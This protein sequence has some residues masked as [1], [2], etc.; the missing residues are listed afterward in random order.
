MF[1]L[2]L[3]RFP[4]PKHKY[5]NHASQQRQKLS[6]QIMGYALLSTI[7]RKQEDCDTTKRGRESK[8]MI[9]YLICFIILAQILVVYETLILHSYFVNTERDRERERERERDRERQRQ[10]EREREREIEAREKEKGYAKEWG[11]EIK[12]GQTRLRNRL[13]SSLKR[14]EI[15]I[16]TLPNWEKF[17]NQ[18]YFLAFNFVA[19]VGCSTKNISQF[20]L[21]RL[22]TFYRGIADQ[23][24]TMGDN[25]L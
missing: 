2:P 16:L 10:R 25:I 15:N 11:N 13:M 9:I 24:V 22:F 1:T 4:N 20:D 18:N 21:V 7:R 14:S 8:E 6:A 23:Y 19:S 12:C 17:C 5:I 3:L